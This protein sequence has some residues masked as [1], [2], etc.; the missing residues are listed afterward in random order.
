MYQGGLGEKCRRGVGV[1]KRRRGFALSASLLLDVTGKIGKAF[2]V[3]QY[4]SNHPIKIRPNQS[5]PADTGPALQKLHATDV[6]R[7]HLQ[8]GEKQSA[9]FSYFFFFSSLCSYD[10]NSSYCTREEEFMFQV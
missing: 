3:M 1:V 7:V 2:N 10:F 4:L 5:L 9:G 6:R 8:G